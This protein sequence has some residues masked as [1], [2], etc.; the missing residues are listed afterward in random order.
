MWRDEDF[1]VP[2]HSCKHRAQGLASTDGRGRKPNLGFHFG[3]AFPILLL[4]VVATK[5]GEKLCSLSFI[6]LG[7]DD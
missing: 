4:S 7:Y 2:E 6:T 3:L 1:A 5:K